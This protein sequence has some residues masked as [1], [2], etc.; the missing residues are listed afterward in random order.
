MT[1]S[2]KEFLKRLPKELEYI[3]GYS[4][5]SK[6]ATFRCKKCSHEWSPIAQSAL[7]GCAKCNRKIRAKGRELFTQKEFDA[8]LPKTVKRTT[9]YK[10]L[11]ALCS[12]KCKTCK[13]E[14]TTKAGRGFKGC[15]ECTKKE[16]PPVNKKTPEEYVA[17]LQSVA[18]DIEVLEDYMGAATSIL[19]KHSLCGHTWKAKPL[20]TLRGRG[21]PKCKLRMKEVSLGSKKVLVRGYEDKALALMLKRFT[22][23][24][25][26][27]QNE[28]QVPTINYKFR[29]SNRLYFPDIYVP[30]INTLVE[31]KSLST[32]GVLGNFYKEKPADLFYLTKAKA[33]ATIAE[34]YKFKL[35]VMLEDGTSLK[36]PNNWLE[37]S[38][39]AFKEYALVYSEAR[40]QR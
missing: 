32:I 14:W 33:R 20:N 37:L 28:K 8:Q 36:L 17:Q 5:Q 23:K 9:P 27:V 11:V 4:I 40:K 38:H 10:T 3:S 13:Y 19:H 22:A 21:C 25:I 29:G 35:L 7:N 34:G 2:E 31:V 39:R 12:F 16:K 1:I 6:R 18:S 15:Y 26:R 24:Q 30:H